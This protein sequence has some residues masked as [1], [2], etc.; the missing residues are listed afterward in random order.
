MTAELMIMAFAVA[1]GFV[2]AGV[3]SSFYQLVTA[4]PARFDLDGA[5]IWSSLAAVIM[6]MFAGPAI[7]MRNAVR[8]RLIERRPVGWL[9]ASTA[10]AGAW[11]LC[12]GVVVL[13]FALALRDSMF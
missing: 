10:V 13:E 6:L 9:A 5:S 11:S 7:L 12:S 3:L 2:S 1:T 8:A 4:E